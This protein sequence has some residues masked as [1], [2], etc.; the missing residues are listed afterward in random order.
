M[1]KRIHQSASELPLE[2]QL[3]AFAA[4]PG[5]SITVINDCGDR[6][7]QLRIRTRLH[8][9]FP[10]IPVDFCEVN[11]EHRDLEAAGCIIDALDA[12]GGGASPGIILG[13]V[14][15]REPEKSGDSN[16]SPFGHCLIGKVLIKSTIRG[17]TLSLVKDFY[18]IE[19]IRVVDPEEALQSMVATGDL[20]PEWVAHI[21]ESQFRS[22]EFQPLLA[23]RLMNGFPVPYRK[24]TLS[25]PK[26]G[27]VVWWVDKHGNCKTTVTTS[28]C[29]PAP[30]RDGDEF[31]TKF[32]TFKYFRRLNDAPRGIPA[33]T[34]GSSGL[35]AGPDNRFLEVAI[36]MGSAAKELGIKVGDG[37]LPE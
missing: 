2:A 7:E 12:K 21:A 23:A 5:F 11:G 8:S 14:A 13:N 33:V 30:L 9:Q 28:Q 19:H 15:Y 1:Q 18:G 34:T 16:G 31:A 25:C 6:N 27:A 10:N 36:R 3:K 26:T 29:Q 32:G 4:Q 22:Y 37:F 17:R 20:E 35:G 24:E